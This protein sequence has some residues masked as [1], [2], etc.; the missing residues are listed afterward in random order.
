M[1]LG[2]ASGLTGWLQM[3]YRLQSVPWEGPRCI[4]WTFHMLPHMQPGPAPALQPLLWL[5]V[6]VEEE[7]EG[8]NI[9]E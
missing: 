1:R 5:T 4:L 6:G 3:T 2:P 8:K 9:K 7:E